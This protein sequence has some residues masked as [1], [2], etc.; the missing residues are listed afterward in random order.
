M[1]EVFFFLARS[2]KATAKALACLSSLKALEKLDTEK[3][4]Y[5]KTE[6][7]HVLLHTQP[8]LT[9]AGELQR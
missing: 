9:R 3:H 1:L 8:P 4:K 2:V 7:C 6:I 5:L